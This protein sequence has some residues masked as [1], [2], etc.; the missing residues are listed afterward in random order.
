MRVRLRPHSAKEMTKALISLGYFE[1]NRFG[2]HRI[3]AHVEKNI[4][5]TVPDR[6]EIPTGTIAKI[7]RKIGLSISEFQAVVDKCS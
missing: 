1:N 4:E 6:K 3:Y 2:S 5:V 7:I